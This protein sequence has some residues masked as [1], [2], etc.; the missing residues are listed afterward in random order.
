MSPKAL[1][2]NTVDF[3]GSWWVLWSGD[4]IQP[5]TVNKIDFPPLGGSFLRIETTSSFAHSFIHST[6]MEGAPTMSKGQSRGTGTLPADSVPTDLGADLAGG[7]PTQQ[8]QKHTARF[9]WSCQ[10]SKGEA[11][12]TRA[13]W[14]GLALSGEGR[15]GFSEDVTHKVGA[16][17]R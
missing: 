11:R 17:C 5:T 16:G 15:E 9:G 8:D 6:D 4:A 3:T 14:G 13:G 10:G 12:S 1:F 2:P 7:R